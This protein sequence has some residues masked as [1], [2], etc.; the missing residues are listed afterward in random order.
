[1]RIIYHAIKMHAI[2]G[3]II[4]IS[5]IEKLGWNEI[6]IQ[7]LNPSQTVKFLNSNFVGRISNPASI[8]QDLS[9]CVHE[10]VIPSRGE[11]IINLSK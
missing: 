1:M 9:L 2:C 5:T 6:Q 7:K 8:K 4:K 10:W 11:K 3:L